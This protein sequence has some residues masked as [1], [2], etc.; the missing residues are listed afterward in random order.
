MAGTGKSTIARTVAHQLHSDKRLG[1]S[2]FFSRGSGDR[3]HA[4]RF[5]STITVQMARA[6]PQI[7]IHI[8]EAINEQPGIAQQVMFEQWNKLIL[9]PL[10]K[11]T[12][13]IDKPLPQ[14]MIIVIDALDECANQDDI[15]LILR[16][17]AAT[18]DPMTLK[19]R[20]FVTS[21]PET[22]IRLGF[23]AMST[24]MY[25]DLVLHNVSRSVVE[26]DIRTFL[27]YELG[28]IRK[29]RGL[30][31]DWPHEQKLKLLVQK[32]NCL[33]IY[34]ATA[35]LYICGPPRISPEKRLSNLVSGEA[36]DGAST[37]NLDEMYTQ[38]LRDSVA[39]DYSDV[40]KRDLTDQFRQVVGSI[41]VLFDTLSAAALSKLLSQPQTELID[42]VK[43][44]LDPLHS[45]LS[46][47]EDVDSPIGLLH[48][49]FRD[50][51]L[52]PRRCSEDQFRVDSKLA[53]SNLV[54]LCLTLMS[55]LLRENMCGLS[56]PGSLAFD[57]EKHEV[58]RCIPAPL[59]YAC[60]Y[61]VDHLLQSYLHLSDN[62]PVQIFLE[63]HLLHWLEALSLTRKSSEGLNILIKLEANLTVSYC[64][65][66]PVPTTILT[67]LV[68]SLLK[69][70]SC[71]LLYT[72]RNDLF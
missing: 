59:Q 46:I 56:S 54:M 28:R 39:G 9:Q 8:C 72:M 32:A 25:E 41:V 68:F 13:D 65:N 66:S 36:A 29:E 18:K 15:K 50:F 31:T 64:I 58:V 21:R 11:A 16:L 4:K 2:F 27:E 10:R 38:I 22:S 14:P 49:S 61:W 53:H 69:R 63:E 44:T 7:R 35:C 20:V 30:P 55:N 52:D 51:L 60:R 40:E 23:Q 19:L 48:P 12:D 26:N 71:Y 45:V 62:G 67:D 3:G 70:L 17:L 34:A 42:V 1:A 43:L 33:F 37:K 6:L 57:I 24:I 47:P 5:F